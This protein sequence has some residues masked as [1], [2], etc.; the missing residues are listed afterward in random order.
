MVFLAV[1][2]ALFDVFFWEV[3]VSGLLAGVMYALVALGF[4]LIF[5]SSGIFN[6]AQGVLALF[7]GLTLVGF[8]TGQVPFAH[9]INWLLGTE[10]HHWGNGVHT[11]LAILFSL[12][13]MIL[14]A[15]V[16][17]R[18]VLRPLVNQEGIMLFMATIGLAFVL[19]GLGDLMWGA[20]VKTLD[21][22]LPTGPSDAIIDLTG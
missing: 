18:V 2:G 22:G 1:T 13:V 20:N 8:Q 6:F 3:V 11:V 19:E 21:V 15:W 9:M 12:V 17:V 16:V 7:A 10:I 5:K 14:L 4:V